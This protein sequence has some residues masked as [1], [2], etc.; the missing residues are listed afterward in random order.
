MTRTRPLT[1]AGPSQLRSAALGTVVQLS[2]PGWA[3]HPQQA[4]WALLP[5]QGI[6]GLT[7]LLPARSC[8]P[9]GAQ[10]GVLGP[11]EEGPALIEASALLVPKKVGQSAGY[12]GL[13]GLP[14]GAGTNSALPWLPW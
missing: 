13:T 10:P 1:P 6:P 14:S 8:L 4:S 2:P 11:C 7:P 3:I 5:S 9:H 12:P